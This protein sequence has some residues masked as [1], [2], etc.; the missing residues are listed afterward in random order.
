MALDPRLQTLTEGDA[1]YDDG[2]DDTQYDPTQSG[3]S[4]EDDELF[5]K[6]LMDAVPDEVD[7]DSDVGAHPDFQALASGGVTFDTND[8]A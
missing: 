4:L 3:V 8:G 7:P 1:D 2:V 6:E 5:G